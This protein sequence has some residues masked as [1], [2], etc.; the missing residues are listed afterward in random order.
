MRPLAVINGMLFG[1]IGAIFIGLAVVVF[2]FL[3]LGSE[4]PFLRDELPAL[5]ANTAGFG[6]LAAISALAFFGQLKVTSWRWYAE[7]GLLLG[8]LG[9]AAFFLY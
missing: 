6:L 4:N 9:M 8:L 3:V 7:F 2:V 1:S 5:W